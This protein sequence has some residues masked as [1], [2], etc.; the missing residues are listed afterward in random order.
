MRFLL[1]DDEPIIRNFCVIV[2]ENYFEGNEIVECTN[3]KEA[4]EVLKSGQV[5][6]LII[7]DY[8]MPGGNG[9]V[10]ADFLD[11]IN[12]QHSYILH[13]SNELEHL[14]VMEEFIS[15]SANR[16]F[17]QKPVALKDLI[18]IIEQITK[19][20]KSDKDKYHRI[21]IEYF[22]RFNKS[23]CD[24]YVQ[25]NSNKY[26]KVIN[27]GSNYQLED[28]TKY[29]E[30]NQRYLYINA[31]DC[32][33]F[34]DTFRKTSFLEFLN[35]PGSEEDLA[36][37]IH[38]VL[39]GLVSTVGVDANTIEMTSKYIS[40]V[41][42]V[43]KDDDK[44]AR[45][46]FKMRN[47]GDY[48]YD[49]SYMTAC[50]GI[51]ILK[52]LPWYSHAMV[53][54]LG[55]AAIFHDITLDDTRLAQITDST[56]SLEELNLSKEEITKVKKHGFEIAKLLE[57][58]NQ[59]DTDLE[60]IL[61]NHHERPNGQG[62]PKGLTASQIRPLTA[63]FILSHEFVTQLYKYDFDENKHKDILTFLFN[64]YNSGNFKEIFDAL[65]KT[66]QLSDKF[67]S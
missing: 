66:L 45:L 5:F 55:K 9:N 29:L 19:V 53:D 36:S 57:R 39:K 28:I 48:L 23:L 8:D 40:T 64:E 12:Y 13:T 34:V 67:Q 63:L 11:S 33:H 54:K 31:N 27:G 18:S 61:I 58:A 25:L 47:K 65:Y 16:K 37:R 10:L 59:L 2:I 20:Q 15:K 32:N 14:P 38:I 42:E 17:L 51:F 3:A 60:H 35:E 43:A 49:H 26:I 50:V 24:V 52:Q 62:F 7:S 56:S 41:E 44:L 22:M 21:R 46:L 1:L 4:I 30:K 6:D